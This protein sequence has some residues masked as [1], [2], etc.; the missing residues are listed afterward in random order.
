[1]GILTPNRR[2]RGLFSVPTTLPRFPS[3]KK[4]E[5]KFETNT[6]EIIPNILPLSYAL[7][8]KLVIINEHAVRH[9]NLIVV[10]SKIGEA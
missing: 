7:N 9:E 3:K 4:G 1:M 2:V 10:S 8:L 5:T 6:F